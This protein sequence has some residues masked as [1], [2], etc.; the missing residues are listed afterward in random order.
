VTR[1]LHEDGAECAETCGRY[2]INNIYSLYVFIW[3]IE[4]IITIHFD[5]VQSRTNVVD[6]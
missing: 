5:F 1:I 2:V 3:Y 6:A 4:D